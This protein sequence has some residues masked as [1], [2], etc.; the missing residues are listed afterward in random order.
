MPLIRKKNHNPSSVGENKENLCQTLLEKTELLKN[1][2][3]KNY[4]SYPIE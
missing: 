1:L 3:R 2:Y 4:S